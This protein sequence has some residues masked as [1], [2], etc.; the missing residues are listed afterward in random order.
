M[1]VDM[2]PYSLDTGIKRYNFFVLFFSFFSTENSY[3]ILSLR[4]VNE[5]F[6][7]ELKDKSSSEFK[8]LDAKITT[9]VSYRLFSRI[10]LGLEVV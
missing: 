9:E 7:D 10:V 8:A 3:Y 5:N 2:L 1:T 6:T 4:I